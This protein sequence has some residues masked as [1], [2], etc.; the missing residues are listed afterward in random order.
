MRK[1][2]PDGADNGSNE[3]LGKH[4]DLQQGRPQ[5]LKIMLVSLVRQRSHLSDQQRPLPR[6][7]APKRNVA[8]PPRA[9]IPHPTHFGRSAITHDLSEAAVI[10]VK[11]ALLRCDL[12]QTGEKL[13]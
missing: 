6:V 8:K 12:L 1:A 13:L 10:A 4:D 7:V 2:R 3:D 11:P 9:A 5:R